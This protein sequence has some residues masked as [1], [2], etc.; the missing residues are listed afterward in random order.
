MK[1][2]SLESLPP[3]SKQLSTVHDGIIGKQT[4]SYP[5]LCTPLDSFTNIL[6]ACPQVLC[7]FGSIAARVSL[8]HLTIS[9]NCV[10]CPA[11]KVPWLH[12]SKAGNTVSSTWWVSF[13]SR[14]VTDWQTNLCRSLQWLVSVIDKQKK[15][16]PNKTNWQV[17]E[18]TK[19]SALKNKVKEAALEVE[20]IEGQGKP[21]VSRTVN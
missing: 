1:G 4:G 19:N 12:T 13:L 2:S 5:P 3:L 8:S 7:A 14:F 15:F 10:L 11:H 6:H 20:K 9:A 21:R 18:V 16:H 17:E